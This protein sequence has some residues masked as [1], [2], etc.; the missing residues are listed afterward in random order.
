MSA[1]NHLYV[2]LM[3]PATPF[4]QDLV[5]A[6]VLTP[7]TSV[8]LC[9][10][11]IKHEKVDQFASV[12]RS[13]TEPR[14]RWRSLAA[15]CVVQGTVGSYDKAR[16]ML[17]ALLGSAD[18]ATVYEHMSALDCV[19]GRTDSALRS[20]QCAARLRGEPM[21]P[22]LDP[23]AEPSVDRPHASRKPGRIQVVQGDSDSVY[24][25]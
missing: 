16:C 13:R 23:T 1:E 2:D 5:S 20:S 18:D 10:Y 8:L 9:H 12:L 11:L 7:E 19:A 4:R 14:E 15:H 17:G 3:L 22:R 6:L 24:V 25:Y 21:K